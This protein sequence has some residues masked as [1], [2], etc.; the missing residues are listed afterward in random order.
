[1]KKE[2]KKVKKG[3][4]VFLECMA[5]GSLAMIAVVPVAIYD[6]CKA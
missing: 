3:L 1:M 6:A 5:I 4:L 2:Q